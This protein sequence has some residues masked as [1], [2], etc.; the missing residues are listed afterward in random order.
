MISPSAALNG[1][2]KQM[3][4]FKHNLTF[5]NMATKLLRIHSDSSTNTTLLRNNMNLTSLTKEYHVHVY[6]VE[7]RFL[8]IK[9]KNKN[10]KSCAA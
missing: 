8:T 5:L 3:R 7:T 2:E 10:T 1:Q 4:H 6:K 9:A